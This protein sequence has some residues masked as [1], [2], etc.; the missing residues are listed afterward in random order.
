M[1]STPQQ[2][3]VPNT[4][5][6]EAVERTLA[7][8]WQQTA[9]QSQV[10]REDAVLRAR[11][12]NIMVFLNNDSLLSE[13][14]QI[15]S[16]LASIHPCRALL[17]VGD[18]KAAARDIEMYVSA[19]C[20]T[21]R[22]SESRDLCCEEIS[23]AARGEFVSELASAA[24]P[25]LV[26]DLPVFLWWR[27]VL[28][29]EDKIFKQL[30]HAANRVVIDSAD[31]QDPSS[32]LSAVAALFNRNG[33][34]AIVL[35][36]INWARLTPWRAALANFYDVQDYR[37]ALDQMTEV[38]IDYVA[39]KTSAFSS[40]AL[41]IA[42]W[43]ASRLHWEFTGAPRAQQ[44]PASVSFDLTNKTRL[45]KLHLNEV[46][47]PAMKSGRL[48]Q[49]ELKASG[50][51]ASFLVSRSADG[52]HLETHATIGELSCPSCWLPVRNQSTAQL[53]SRE[54][55]ILCS[56]EIYEEAIAVAASM[57]RLQP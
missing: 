56:D 43:L 46:Q 21:Q 32:D 50:A 5:D 48:A 13:T 31:F 10:D 18:R 38:R 53:L 41:L 37:V 24:V 45:I 28:G 22:R 9:G 19:F 16:E 34:E 51:T 49:I 14:Q 4:L 57:A 3:H 54:M 30:G 27:E 2:I 26:S 7:E 47:R 33:D 29:A 11:A 23:L 6:V 15:I 55:E 40:Q 8:L 12:A 52:L 44:S 17:M 20:A 36:D 42:G 39:E 35:S 25:L 1:Y